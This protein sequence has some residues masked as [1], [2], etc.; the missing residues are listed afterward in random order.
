MC[1]IHTVLWKHPFKMHGTIEIYRPMNTQHEQKWT[2]QQRK[3]KIKNRKTENCFVE[4]Q[5]LISHQQYG[6]KVNIV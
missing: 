4:M 5:Y 1:L 6:L 2:E 3:T